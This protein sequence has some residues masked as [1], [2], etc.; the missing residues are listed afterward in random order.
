MRLNKQHQQGSQLHPPYQM[1]V[2]FFYL[3]IFSQHFPHPS[4]SLYTQTYFCIC[5]LSVLS[6]NC[7]SVIQILVSEVRTFYRVAP[8]LSELYAHTSGDG[9]PYNQLI[10]SGIEVQYIMNSDGHLYTIQK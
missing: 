5:N 2:F 10:N 6:L 1:C 4:I 8:Q 7:L 9:I 3:C